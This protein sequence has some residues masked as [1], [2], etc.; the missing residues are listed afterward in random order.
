MPSKGD[1]IRPFVVIGILLWLSAS[2][3]I[4]IMCFELVYAIEDG[5]SKELT[6]QS[7]SAWEKIFVNVLPI[8]G[9]LGGIFGLITGLIF[10]TRPSYEH[11]DIS[12]MINNMKMGLP[13]GGP[14]T[15]AEIT[16]SARAW[17]I[18]FIIYVGAAVIIPPYYQSELILVR[19]ISARVIIGF[20]TGVVP[21]T[22]VLPC[23]LGYLKTKYDKR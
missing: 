16:T 17:F 22:M 12:P 1:L 15:M 18:G 21:V 7:L 5:D 20:L 10:F 23:S 11:M 14:K 19:D 2:A 9:G 3:F 8:W 6:Q 4:G 13:P